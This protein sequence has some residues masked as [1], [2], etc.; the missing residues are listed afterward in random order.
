MERKTQPWK[1]RGS[2]FKAVQTHHTLGQIT[3]NLKRSAII[4]IVDFLK[5]KTRRK[6]KD[7]LQGFQ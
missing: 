5:K 2:I 3:T 6:R 4:I 7:N 1:I